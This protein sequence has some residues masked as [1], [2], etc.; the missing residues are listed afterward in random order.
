M[1]TPI[2]TK[3]ILHRRDWNDD[4]KL[5]LTDEQI[6]LLEWLLDKQILCPDIWDLQVLEED[7]VWEEI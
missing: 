3:V 6:A 1:A 5:S 4:E 2:R 7:E